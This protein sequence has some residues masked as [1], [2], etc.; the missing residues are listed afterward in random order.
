MLIETIP[1]DLIPPFTFCGD[2]FFLEGIQ[3]PKAI[4][5]EAAHIKSRDI[6]DNE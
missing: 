3:E 4:H 6:L 2:P 5:D 1:Y